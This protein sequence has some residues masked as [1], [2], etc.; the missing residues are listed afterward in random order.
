MSGQIRTNIQN[1]YD[2]S[3]AA[4]ALSLCMKGRLYAWSRIG[5]VAMIRRLCHR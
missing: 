1:V 2:E 3:S 4:V 5:T